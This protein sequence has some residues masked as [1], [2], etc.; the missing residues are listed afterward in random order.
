MKALAHTGL[1]VPSI[2]LP[3]LGADI[4]AWSVIACDQYTQDQ[5]Y[6]DHVERLTAG[7]P[8][9]LRLILPE[10]YLERDDCPSR[11]A[12]IHNEM[13]RCLRE[14][15]FAPEFE[16]LVLS[17]RTTAFGRKR[18]GLL[19]AVDLDAYDWRSHSEAL[20]RATE[21]TITARIPPRMDI[22]R[23]APLELPHIM[24]LINDEEKKLMSEAAACADA[25]PLY[26]S[27]LMLNGGHVRGWAITKPAAWE[28][29]REVIAAIAQK[30]RGF[31]FAVGDGNH[32]LAAAKAIWEER[33]Q[34]LDEGTESPVRYALAEIV[35]IYDEGLTFEP[36][37][38]ALFNVDAQ[39]LMDFLCPRLGAEIVQ[40][41]SAAEAAEL[42]GSSHAHIALAFSP[43]AKDTVFMLLKTH[44]QGL[45]VSYV[46]PLLD[47]FIEMQKKDGQTVSIDY[48]H[49]SGE[50]LSL[51]EREGTAAILM[52][53]IKKESF[54]STIAE[55]GVLPRK[56]FSM[57]E[58]DEKRFYLEAR[59]LFA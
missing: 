39:R 48:I 55:C 30:N 32:S 29:L 17:E 24:L 33:Q 13:R 36:I 51:A 21:K 27:D 57:G 6:W 25:D 47:E 59:R 53:P 31:L 37:H 50:T 7:L 40:L 22:R 44:I 26:D 28:R 52:P 45:A 23:G 15:V 49:G 5:A 43:R 4:R 3:G 54:F 41:H 18:R 42:V 11:I 2:L 16:G 10:I 46:Q 19:A 35:N 56:S 58:A 38:R 34:A 1:A 9:S 14:G 20:I 12:S 8:S